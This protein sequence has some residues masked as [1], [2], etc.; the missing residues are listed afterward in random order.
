MFR[1]KII[2]T[3]RPPT[4]NG[5]SSFKEKCEPKLEFPEGFGS[6]GIQTK[7]TLHGGCMDFFF[8]NTMLNEV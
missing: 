5:A 4:P 3:L 1:P 2:G 7:K 8:D 6:R